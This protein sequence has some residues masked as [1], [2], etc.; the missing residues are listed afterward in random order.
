MDARTHEEAARQRLDQLIRMTP[1]ESYSSVSALI[2]RNHAYIQQY[3]R[4]GQPRRLQEKDRRRIAA[5]FGVSESDLGGMDFPG[6]SPAGFAESPDGLIFI[7]Q[8]DVRAKGEPT[9]FS[10][11][12]HADGF[13]PFR[14]NLLRRLT[15]SGPDRLALISVAGDSMYPTLADGDDIL[16]DLGETAPHRDA[17]YAIRME[18]TLQVK[19]VS[20]NPVTGFLSIKSDNPLYESWNDCDPASVDILGRVVW[21]GRRL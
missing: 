18:N 19:R 3:I 20:V 8:F 21:V 6:P 13:A 14:Q 4:R 11:R 17:I 5:H 9:A 2:G 1:G 16:I 12:E 15:R 7:P 10:N